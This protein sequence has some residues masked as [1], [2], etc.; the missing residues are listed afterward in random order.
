LGGA[1]S[2]RNSAVPKPIGTAMTRARSVV[3][4]VPTM[5][6]PAPYCWC[7]GFHEVHRIERPMWLNALEDFD[8]SVTM[9]VRKTVAKM[10]AP[11]HRM[12]V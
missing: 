4:R 7:T 6:G 11:P 2:V 10:A 8:S 3:S 1:I 5:K 12:A 9:S